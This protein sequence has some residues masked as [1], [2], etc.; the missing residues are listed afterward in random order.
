MKNISDILFIILI[1]LIAGCHAGL[2]DDR[3][4]TKIAYD[5]NGAPT[6]IEYTNYTQYYTQGGAHPSYG[7]DD[8]LFLNNGY[9]KPVEISF[10]VYYSD[11][12]PVCCYKIYIYSNKEV[13]F[14]IAGTI[15]KIELTS[16]VFK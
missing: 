10:K 11:S 6:K 1:F 5:Q 14:S 9:D 7:Q 4:E 15:V 3:G 13:R 2:W 16:I 8:G 12:E